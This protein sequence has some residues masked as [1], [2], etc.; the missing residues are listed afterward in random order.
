MLEKY[1]KAALKEEACS[2]VLKNAKYV[3]VFTHKLCTG[4]IAIKD[5]KIVG[6][7]SYNGEVEIDC[8]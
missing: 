4:D 3:N 8:T 2:L 7:G 1:I 5:D 6:I